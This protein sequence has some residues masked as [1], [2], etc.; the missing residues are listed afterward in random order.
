MGGGPVLNRGERFDL[1]ASYLSDALG[2][3]LLA[4]WRLTDGAGEARCSWDE[5]P[6]EYRWVFQR[7]GADVDV[8]V[9]WFDELWGRRPDDEGDDVFRAS[10]PLRVFVQALV[11]GACTVQQRHG[12]DGYREQWV[13]HL[14]PAETLDRLHRWLTQSPP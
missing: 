13:E 12:L 9:L 8:R 5:E 14:F 4:A 7:S 10:F 3:L 2:D 1:T 11:D 6:G